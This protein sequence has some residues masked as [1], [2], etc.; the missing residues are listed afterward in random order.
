MVALGS[1]EFLILVKHEMWWISQN[2]K[3]VEYLDSR[4]KVG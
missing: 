2:S 3:S 4:K 1:E